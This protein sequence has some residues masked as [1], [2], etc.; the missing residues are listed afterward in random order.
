VKSK[1]FLIFSLSLLFFYIVVVGGCGKVTPCPSSETIAPPELILTTINVTPES[2]ALTL[3]STQQFASSGI[4]SA[5]SQIIQSINPS[6]EVVGGIGSISS[7]GLFTASAAGSG[8]IIARMGSIEGQAQVT[9]YV[10]PD[11]TPPAKPTGFN[12]AGGINSS[13][14]TWTLNPEPDLY[15]YKIFR[16]LQGESDF[17][18]IAITGKVNSYADS[19][20]PRS[21]GTHSYKI[22]AVDTSGNESEYSDEKSASP[23]IMLDAPS[24]TIENIT[25][26]CATAR[27]NA[28][29][30]ATSYLISYGTDTGAS[31]LGTITTTETCYLLSGLSEDTTYYIKGQAQGTYPGLIII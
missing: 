6:W 24:I 30:D 26:N 10:P 29:S 25:T 21:P 5:G 7:S 4:F 9:V 1:I 17:S 31:N 27:W 16:R 22:R 2:A 8:E 15:R 12:A 20:V 3:G 18:Q 23:T 11:V 19:G 13:A 14:L 28:V